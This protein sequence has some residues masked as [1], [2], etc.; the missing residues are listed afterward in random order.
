MIDYR[1]YLRVF[2]GFLEVVSAGLSE[3]FKCCNYAQCAQVLSIRFCRGLFCIVS[4]AGLPSAVMGPSIL[5]K[6]V[7]TSPA[8]AQLGLVCAQIMPRLQECACGRRS[9]FQWVMAGK[10]NN[11][12]KRQSPP[13]FNRKWPNIPYFWNIISMIIITLTRKTEG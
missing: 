13:S 11:N 2:W 12:K 6:G 3:W 5:G 8:A 7:E 4:W 1:S 9:C 10:Y